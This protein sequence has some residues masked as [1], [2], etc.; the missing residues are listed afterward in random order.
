MALEIL[1]SDKYALART[2]EMAKYR[3]D[4][5]FM[6][7]LAMLRRAEKARLDG[8]ICGYQVWWVEDDP[9]IVDTILIDHFEKDRRTYRVLTDN[10][11][12]DRVGLI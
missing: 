4:H 7:G 5:K 8:H 1:E 2:E 3:N 11:F 6:A 10:E 9:D 12:V